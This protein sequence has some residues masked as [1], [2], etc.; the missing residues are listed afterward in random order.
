[1]S[2]LSTQRRKTLYGIISS[3][4]DFACEGPLGDFVGK[5]LVCEALAQ[6]LVGYYKEDKKISRA[7]NQPLSWIE[8]DAAA[9][10][11]SIGLSESQ[12]EETFKAG[13]RRKRGERTPRQLRN[14]YF[15][16]LSPKDAQEIIGR[17]KELLTLMDSWISV[18][19]KDSSSKS[20]EV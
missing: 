8:I 12:I 20:W 6:K 16:T 2:R 15:H 11:F 19:E 1:M 7:P 5:Y 10:N 17:S 9:K 13:R 3:S 4:P 18:F 14:G